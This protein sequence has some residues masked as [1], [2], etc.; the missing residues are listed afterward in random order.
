MAITKGMTASIGKSNVN[1]SEERGIAQKLHKELSL[2]ASPVWN[3]EFCTA[4]VGNN[5][6]Y[7]P[8]ISPSRYPIRIHGSSENRTRSS[9]PHSDDDKQGGI[10]WNYCRLRHYFHLLRSVD[11]RYKMINSSTLSDAMS[12]SQESYDWKFLREE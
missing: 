1:F 8:V 2:P 12:G 11:F 7:T 10:G 9:Q 6:T 4:P 3:S 5:T